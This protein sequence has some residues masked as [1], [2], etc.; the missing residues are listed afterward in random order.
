[1]KYIDIG[2]TGYLLD[3]DSDAILNEDG[4]FILADEEALAQISYMG[5]QEVGTVSSEP[6]THGVVSGELIA[7]SPGRELVS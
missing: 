3:E 4:G 2:Y 1:M 5:E 7:S 6:A